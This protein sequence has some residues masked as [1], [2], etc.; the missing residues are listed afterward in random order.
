MATLGCL[1]LAGRGR[2]KAS[3]NSCRKTSVQGCRPGVLGKSLHA[4]PPNQGCFVTE[5]RFSLMLK[6]GLIPFKGGTSLE[7]QSLRRDNSPTRQLQLVP[8]ILKYSLGD[9]DLSLPLF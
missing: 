4:S 8:E 7:P 2:K 6:K 3:R 9:N 5:T 1:F